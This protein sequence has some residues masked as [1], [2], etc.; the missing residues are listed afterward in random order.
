MTLGMAWQ[1]GRAGCAEDDPGLRVDY[2]AGP[3]ADERIS[4][5]LLRR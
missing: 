4:I 1:L 5:T 2:D 3:A